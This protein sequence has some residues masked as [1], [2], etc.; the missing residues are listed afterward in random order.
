MDGS[1]VRGLHPDL[2]ALGQRDD[3]GERHVVVPD[4]E[5]EPPPQSAP[6]PVTECA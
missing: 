6:S 4:I 2:L 1:D 5:D 3:P